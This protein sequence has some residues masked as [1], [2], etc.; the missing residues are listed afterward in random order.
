MCHR[1]KSYFV[2]AV[3]FCSRIY[4]VMERNHWDNSD[5]NTYCPE[6]QRAVVLLYKHWKKA[7]KSKQKTLPNSSVKQT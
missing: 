6:N 5:Q 3:Y 1:I 2:F 4:K 7:I